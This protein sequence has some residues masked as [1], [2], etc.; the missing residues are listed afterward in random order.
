MSRAYLSFALICSLSACGDD[1]RPIMF[2]GGRLPDGAIPD[3]FVNPDAG[4]DVMPGCTPPA[5]PQPTI[6][7]CPMAGRPP[8]ATGTCTV[9]A[10]SAARLIRADVLT[11]GEVF[12]GG[13]VL[14]DATGSI[15][16]VGCDCSAMGAGATVVD[17]P[18]AVVSPGLI[19]THEHI[20]FAQG[21]PYV[22]TDER[23][24]HRH[25]WR[26][27][28]RGHTEVGS[29]GS[30]SAAEVMWGELRYVLGGGTS[31]NGSGSARGFLRN[32]DRA[33]QEGL[34]QPQVDYD[35]F[36][37]GDTGG[38][39]RSMGCGYPGGTT[40]MDIA[41]TESY[42]P[43]ISEGIDPEARNEFLCTREGM[44]DLIAPQTAVIHGVGLLPPDIG[45][46]SADGASLIWSPRSNVA[47][48]GDTANVTV[49]DALGVPIAL[50]TDWIIS[51]SMNIL[52]ELACADEL[53]Q[54]YYG[55]YFTDEQL[56]L[57]TTANAA[58]ALAVDDVLGTIA[59]GQVG[60]LAIFA[61]SGRTDH[62]AILEAEASDVVLVLRNGVPLYGDG[63]LVSGLGASGCDTLDVC[64]T[65][66]AVCAMRETGMTLAALQSANAMNYPLFFCGAPMNEPS[67]LPERNAMAPLPSPEV[68]GSTRYTGL[69]SGD[70]G[71]GDGIADAA[72]NCVCTFN[73]VRPVDNG[74]QGD[75]DMDGAGDACDPCPLNPGLSGCSPPDPNDRDADGV[76]N[77]EDN[78]P[79]DP[80]PGQE[81]MDDDGKGDACDPCP[82]DANPGTAACPA[83]I[84]E[85][86]GGTFEVGAS[87]AIT[88]AVVTGVGANGFFM[89]VPADHPMYAGP[90]NSG[91]F[92]FTSMAP[93][94]AAGDRVTLSSSLVSNFFGQIQ[95]TNAMIMVTESGLTAPA[96]VTVTPPE[97]A[98]GGARALTLEGVIVRVTDAMVVNAMPAM[99]PG[100]RAPTNEFEI[101]NGIRVDDFLYF[102]DPQPMMGETIAELTGVLA[103]RN[104]AN[105]IEP[106]NATDVVFGDAALLELAPA[107]TFRRVGATAGPTIPDP[108][109]VRLTRATD[110]DVTISMMSSGAGLTVADVLVPAGEREAVVP[111]RGVTASPTPYTV[112]ASYMGR[113]RTATVR[114]IG[115]AEL[116]VLVSLTPP[117]AM[118]PIMSAA[119]YAVGLD[120]PAPAG[121][122]NVML[123]AT[124][125]G[126]VPAM[127]VVPADALA[128]SFDFTA[129]AM[130]GMATIS[131]TLGPTSLMAMAEVVASAAGS[132]VINEVDYDQPAGDTT[133]FIEIY[134]AGTSAIDLTGIAVVLVN[135]ATTMME[136]DRFDL[137]GMIA[138]G[139]YIVIANAA[140]VTPAGVPRILLGDSGFQN[141]APDGLAIYDTTMDR[142]V[143]ALSYEGSVSG[144]RIE[145]AA[146]PR[147]LVEGTATTAVDMGA[148]SL[149]RIPNGRDTNMASAD[150]A[151]TAT[152]TPGAANVP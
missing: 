135:G 52:R 21:V 28:A 44:F 67:C 65:Q 27:G 57:M 24:E 143:D 144:A 12:R 106:R 93:A 81:D 127:V 34:M 112:T 79:S 2:D 123:S 141:G 140:V 146:M 58:A 122:T 16:C 142:I 92:V 73:P 72:D 129:A 32:L 96:P 17:C 150:W 151:L 40:A 48:Y 134:N 55:G 136:Y 11:P 131:A 5:T 43:H 117:T 83:T 74:M 66:K 89:Q 54:T 13:E 119:P 147:T 97:I 42:T 108:L 19:N 145:G 9:T 132:L 3:G 98:V 118:V 82:M 115:A 38:Q 20:T 86:K 30:S 18:E 62:R 125:A 121:G 63:A 14:V 26:T 126:T 47:L 138:P 94:V 111:V 91:V 4:P 148:G 70:D 114:V 36:P 101:Q 46:L 95:L 85:V 59:V 107:S 152:T 6:T 22:G 49:Y 1:D 78:C 53:N 137:T 99:G 15:T 71:D 68:N 56:W 109:V 39:L 130:P 23:Y 10:G 75:F 124:G 149:S 61:R 120:I 80:N 33:D 35:T 45:E 41:G 50:G 110:A 29:S 51:G 105:K 100:D 116:P 84:Y 87:V 128:Q 88:G 90:D 139:G 31:L 103:F 25:D 7:M 102:I 8:P 37:L 76:A 77:A 133:E 69:A 113:M 104:D 64:G 60:D